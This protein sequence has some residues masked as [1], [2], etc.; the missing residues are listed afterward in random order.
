MIFPKSRGM[1]VAEPGLDPKVWGL[2]VRI[3]TLL[4]LR[5]HVTVNFQ[6]YSNFILFISQE[7]NGLY[8]HFKNPNNKGKLSTILIHWH[9]FTSSMI[10]FKTIESYLEVSAFTIWCDPFR[11]I[12]AHFYTYIY[13]CIDILFLT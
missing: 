10:Y 3:T 4:S 11:P 7:I 13:T 2:R 8:S 12:P 9:L 1:S 6:F 5:K